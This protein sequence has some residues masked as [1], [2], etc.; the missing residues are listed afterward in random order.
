MPVDSCVFVTDV[1]G[2]L[3]DRGALIPELS[4]AG[5]AEA[6]SSLADHGGADDITGAM[7]AKVVA[8]RQVAGHGA[9]AVIVNGLIPGRLRAALRGDPVTGTRVLA[10]APAAPA[11]AVPGR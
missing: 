8:A 5:L 11:A 9:A 6:G 1:D 3:D 10:P 2:V 4:A 7:D